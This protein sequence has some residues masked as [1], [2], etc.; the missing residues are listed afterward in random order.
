MRTDLAMRRSCIVRF[1]LVAL[2]AAPRLSF[3]ERG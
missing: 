1:G 2:H 3:S